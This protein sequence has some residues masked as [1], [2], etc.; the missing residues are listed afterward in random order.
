MAGIFRA[1]AFSKLTFIRPYE[2]RIEPN[3]V[4]GD[5]L[6]GLMAEVWDP[7][8]M[9]GRQWQV[10]EFAGEDT[11]TPIRV[12]VHAEFDPLV[13]WH[14]GPFGPDRDWLPLAPGELLEPLVEREAGRDAEGGAGGAAPAASA[15]LAASAGAALQQTLLELGE[16]TLVAA[17]LEHC[18]APTPEPGPDGKPPSGWAAVQGVLAGRAVDPFEVARQFAGERPD[19]FTAALRGSLERRR[20]AEGAV[21]DWLVWFDAEVDREVAPSSWLGDRLEYEFAVATTSAVL[22]APQHGAGEIGWAT[23]DSDPSR[24]PPPADGVEPEQIDRALLASQLSFPGMPVSRFWEFEDADIDLGAAFAD[25]HELARLAVVEAAIMAGDDWLVVPVDSPPGGVLRVTSVQWRDTFGAR[26]HADEKAPAVPAGRFTPTWR[27]YST[28]ERAWEGATGEVRRD[29]AGLFVPPAIAARLEGAAIE[30]VRFVR[31]ETAN[32]VWAIEQTVPADSGD[33]RI[34]AALPAP[35][36]PA[37][38]PG[39]QPADQVLGYELMTYVPTN[40]FPYLARISDRGV[41]LERAD[42]DRG[43]KGVEPAGRLLDEEEQR[44]LLAAEV[45]RQGVRVQRVPQAARRADGSWV[46]WTGRRVRPAAGEAESGLEFDR[47]RR[48]SPPPR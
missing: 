27:M 32:L 25:P 46:L 8:W 10:G 13:A 5:P 33:P 3:P 18:P 43:G 17:L 30:D 44:R 20:R 31:D 21:D 24:T 29:L 40:W 37:I 6:V 41:T 19:W 35:P 4:S 34:V 16:R 42:V 1:Q 9:L 15:R 7:L 38:D 48:P 22:H 26:W 28:S 14:P 12:D 45:P 47:T 23:F 39:T 2:T 36:V 11:G